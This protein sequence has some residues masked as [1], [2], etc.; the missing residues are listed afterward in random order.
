MQYFLTTPTHTFTGNTTWDIADHIYST[1][2]KGCGPIVEETFDDEAFSPYEYWDGVVLFKYPDELDEDRLCEYVSWALNIPL[3][4]IKF[5]VVS[6]EPVEELPMMTGAE[7][8]ALR[9]LLGMSVDHLA[10]EL[11]VTSRSIRNWSSGKSRIPNGV[12][13]HLWNETLEL[14]KA[15]D[16]VIEDSKESGE[17]CRLQR[18]ARTDTALAAQVLS[19]FP[20]ARFTWE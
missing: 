13:E 15:V 8:E 17:P 2:D 12:A 9:H 5:T 3:E 16:V 18:G 14:M 11:D 19:R 7:F 10:L 20:G 6:N 1:Q 4:D